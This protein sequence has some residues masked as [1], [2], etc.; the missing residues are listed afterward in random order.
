[1]RP[2]SR[3][4]AAWPPGSADTSL[5][6]AAD[7]H[8]HPFVPGYPNPDTIPDLCPRDPTKKYPPGGRNAAPG[9]S[10]GDYNSGAI[11]PTPTPAA[12]RHCVTD[13]KSIY[14]F[15]VGVDTAAARKQLKKIP[16]KSGSCTFALK[17]P[18]MIYKDLL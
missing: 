13:G 7:G 14:C 3:N 12:W 9:P 15:P 17:L 1:M 6:R 5:R 16:R 4:R 11:T 2:I 8:I 10:P 18:T